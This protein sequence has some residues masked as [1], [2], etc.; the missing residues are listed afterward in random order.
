MRPMYYFD[1]S[2][3][4]LVGLFNSNVSVS[5]TNPIESMDTFSVI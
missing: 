4:Q 2:V 5:T 1:Q 3:A